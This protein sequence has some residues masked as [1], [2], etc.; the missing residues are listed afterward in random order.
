MHYRFGLYVHACVGVYVRAYLYVHVYW[1]RVS[2]YENVTR[3]VYDM[4]VLHAYMR[5]CAFVSR[6]VVDPPIA[7]GP[8]R[9]ATGF[10]CAIRMETEQM[11]PLIHSCTHLPA[12]S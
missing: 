8:N 12:H 4:Y 6:I 1:V 3:C 10:T 11:R 2:V 5:L 9:T 7:V